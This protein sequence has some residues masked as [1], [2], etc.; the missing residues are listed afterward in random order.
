MK[1]T[2]QA[3]P[4]QLIYEMVNGKAIYY[5]GYED[6]L[7]GKKQIEELMGSSYIQSLIITNLVIFLG[8]NLPKS[9]QVLTNEIGLQFSKKS[10]RAADIAIIEKKKLKASDKGNKY[11]KKAPKIVIEIDT[12][13]NIEDV[14]ACWEFAFGA[15]AVK[16]CFGQGVTND[17][18]RS[19][20]SEEQRSTKHNLTRVAQR[21]NSRHALNDVLGYFHKKTD[22]L[23][24]F[25][26]EKVIWIF[27]DSQKVMIAT[28]GK[29]WETHDWNKNI[30]I[31]EKIEANIQQ[32]IAED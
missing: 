25:G 7:S 10:W 28:Q 12:K 14:R 22:E 26:V 3:I 18:S 16:F 32:L 6:Y 21:V 5:K 13:A 20:M 23:L 29:N 8:I 11:I 9:Y 27:T 2:V 17:Y 24:D 1:G 15:N 30:L 4:E 19:Y 31:L